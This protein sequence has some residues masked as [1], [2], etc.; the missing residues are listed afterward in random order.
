MVPGISHALGC[1]A[2]WRSC[3]HS[4]GLK[5]VSLPQSGVRPRKRLLVAG[6]VIKKE[7]IMKCILYSEGTGE[8]ETSINYKKKIIM[9]N[10]FLGELEL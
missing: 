1:S 8:K 2:S 10:E 5:D 3:C 6:P 9:K 4:E 7:E